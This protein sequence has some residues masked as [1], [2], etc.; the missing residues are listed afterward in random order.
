MKVFVVE[1]SPEGM[2]AM[3]SGRRDDP[4][5]WSPLQE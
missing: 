2:L 5:D 3:S 1:H 4:P